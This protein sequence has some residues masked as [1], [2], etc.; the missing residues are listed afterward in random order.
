MKLLQ[1]LYV[2]TQE[3]AQR[4]FTNVKG[5]VSEFKPKYG[6]N[7]QGYIDTQVTVTE[8][9]AN[10]QLLWKPLQ[11]MFKEKVNLCQIV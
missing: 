4:H 7:C 2:E 1:R 3:D 10:L 11:L 8:M 6:E 5:F 9:P